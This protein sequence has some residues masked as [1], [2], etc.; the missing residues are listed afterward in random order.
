MKAN[1]EAEMSNLGQIESEPAL[2]WAYQEHAAAIGD[3]TLLVNQIMATLDIVPKPSPEETCQPDKAVHNK[4]LD[5]IHRLR[6]LTGEIKDLH[7]FV[8]LINDVAREI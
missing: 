6:F 5:R 4:L 3:L 2:L 8:T 1:K 7:R